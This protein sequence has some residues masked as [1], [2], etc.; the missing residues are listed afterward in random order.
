MFEGKPLQGRD[1]QPEETT[2]DTSDE[3]RPLTWGDLRTRLDAARD[4]RTASACR[5]EDRL[6]SFD[7]NSASR[8]AAQADGK[9]A[10]NPDDLAICKGPGLKNDATSATDGDSGSEPGN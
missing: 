3:L 5:V 9:E 8:I 6:A 7:A 2:S 10:V 1:P 4:L